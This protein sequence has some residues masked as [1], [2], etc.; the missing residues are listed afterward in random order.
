MLEQFAFPRSFH[1]FFRFDGLMD[2]IHTSMTSILYNYIFVRPSR[3]DL[4]FTLCSNCHIPSYIFHHHSYS[5]LNNTIHSQ[6]NLFLHGNSGS[7]GNGWFKVSH[8]LQLTIRIPFLSQFLHLQ[9]FRFNHLKLFYG[10]TCTR[11]M[12]AD[13]HIGCE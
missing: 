11:S 4:H 7:P 6:I 1:S 13:G 8:F 3:V 10:G 5:I 2:D 12:E 9:F